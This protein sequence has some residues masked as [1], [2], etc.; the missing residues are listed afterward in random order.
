MIQQI[1]NLA[2]NP[3]FAASFDELR[4]SELPFA[5]NPNFCGRVGML[6]GIRKAFEPPNPV[7]S[8]DS[9]SASGNNYCP[10]QQIYLL[11][12]IGGVGK[13]QIALQYAHESNSRYK[14]VLWINVKDKTS[15]EID[16]FRILQQLVNQYA[17]LS[18]L[19]SD[20]VPNYSK[21]AIELEFGCIDGINDLGK[22]VESSI[23]SAWGILKRWL[24]RKG[25]NNWL[26]VFDNNDVLKADDLIQI[27]PTCNWGHIIITSRRQISSL[28]L[29]RAPYQ[30]HMYV[31][32]Y[33]PTEDRVQARRVRCLN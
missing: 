6:E 11:H 12:G 9:N 13:T 5:L 3:P 8:G 32:T 33:I 30:N 28:C 21:I 25:N 4:I 1:R 15:L 7:S 24:S 14:S 2:S 19:S 18:N 29:K 23:P 16:A 22:I 10:K 27:I 31:H 17:K 20:R 26:V